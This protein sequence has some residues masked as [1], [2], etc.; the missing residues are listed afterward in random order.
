M[1]RGL[2][3]HTA[4]I[5]VDTAEVVV[6]IHGHGAVG[7]WDLAAELHSGDSECFKLVHLILLLLVFK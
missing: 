5:R 4:A 1:H 7:H 2:A 6:L 3:M